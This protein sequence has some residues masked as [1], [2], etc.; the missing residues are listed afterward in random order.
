[1]HFIEHF[2]YVVIGSQLLSEYPDHGLLRSA[3]PARQGLQDP[4]K[5]NGLQTNA[6][7]LVGTGVSAGLAFFIVCLIQWARNAASFAMGKSRILIVCALLILAAA[8]MYAYVRRQWLKYLR[9]QAVGSA[10][11]LT[12][13]MQA[14]E[15]SSVAALSMIQEVELVSKG[16]RL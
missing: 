8:V 15:L 5:H 7:S 16:Y 9:T 3:V 4:D 6:Y 1:M 12:T 10:S 2:R 11:S 13:N 14:F